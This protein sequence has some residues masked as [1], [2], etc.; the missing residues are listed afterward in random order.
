M[1]VIDSGIRKYG[2]FVGKNPFE[3]GFITQIVFLYFA[4]GWLQQETESGVWTELSLQRQWSAQGGLQEHQIRAWED[5][6]DD[7][8]TWDRYLII[9][10]QKWP[11][12]RD[13]PMDLATVQHFQDMMEFA[14][15]WF[16]ITVEVNGNTYSTHDLCRKG[17]YPA[18]LPS[19]QTMPCLTLSGFMCFAEWSRSLPA[20][21]YEIDKGTPAAAEAMLAGLYYPQST[22]PQMS[23]LTDAELKAVMSVR[24][25]YTLQRGCHTF[26]KTLVG[27]QTFFGGSD[28][29]VDADGIITNLPMHF[30]AMYYDAAPR[31]AWRLG[32]SEDELDTALRKH[33]N[34]FTA[35]MEDWHKT[36]PVLD[37][38]GAPS[39]SRIDEELEDQGEE[40]KWHLL[41][42]GAVITG[43]YAVSM[44]TS[45]TWPSYSRVTV[46]MQGNGTILMCLVAAGGFLLLI[47]FRMNL[48][49]ASA[50]PFITLGVG[51]DDMFVL[52]RTF[53]QLGADFVNT[54][55]VSDTVAEVAHKAG[56]GV[57]L[58]SACN[59]IAFGFSSWIPVAN[60]S[61]FCISASVCCIFNFIGMFTIHL[62]TLAY[63]AARVKYYLP[64]AWCAPCHTGIGCMCC[65]PSM[66]C[67]PNR[68]K[69]PP[70]Y[71]FDMWFND[72]IEKK[73]AP[74]ISKLAVS[75]GVVV[76]T[77]ALSVA[78]AISIETRNIGYTP[79]II[80]KD[81]SPLAKFLQVFYSSVKYYSAEVVMYD[82]D[83]ANNQG[84]LLDLF[85]RFNSDDLP[86]ASVNSPFLTYMYTYA[87]NRNLLFPVL[88]FSTFV[89]KMVTMQQYMAA[90][91]TLPAE[92]YTL[93]PQI[94]NHTVF[95][96]SG[97][98]NASVFYDIYREFAY[99]PMEAKTKE[100]MLQY[101]LAP[102]GTWI[103]SLKNSEWMCCNSG[104]F[105][106]YSDYVGNVN[107]FSHYNLTDGSNCTLGKGKCG[108][109]LAYFSFTIADLN[110]HSDYMFAIKKS[111]EL[112]EEAGFSLRH[113]FPMG[114]S[115]VYW[116]LFDMLYEELGKVFITS[117]CV[118]LIVSILLLGDLGAAL[119]IFVICMAIVLQVGGFIC[120]FGYGVDWNMFT[121]SVV[122]ASVAL[123]VE[124]V[125]HTVCFFLAA[126]GSKEEKIADAMKDA[127]IAIIEGSISTV[128]S[129]LPM[130]FHEVPFF[131][132]YYVLPMT[133]LVFTGV[134]NGCVFVPA[135]LILI[136]QTK[137][138]CC[139]RFAPTKEMIV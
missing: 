90:A 60:L 111:D 125:A 98:L 28:V 102:V 74:C 105:F 67:S 10:H 50:L 5:W 85:S 7:S 64:D 51:M 93:H 48:V 16:G 44:L 11:E 57:L 106:W 131:K 104:S 13:E 61:D 17:A 49:M 79:D 95:A 77:L 70:Y 56:K 53:T 15:T 68:G 130:A 23:N 52:T 109:R 46:G 22:R 39:V 71:G 97:I 86:G 139:S 120:F 43:I 35:S 128:I 88:Q 58:T 8:W 133:I 18:Y 45:F 115:Y 89:V 121:S 101:V 94:Y 37:A 34:A 65:P 42:A 9:F 1:G 112:I 135:I 66:P 78:G 126:Q 91:G 107:E 12:K 96:P 103:P 73:Y 29:E 62:A 82:V 54:H 84:A 92:A 122:M 59:T 136:D 99:F 119:V 81:G 138:C 116:K 69:P 113:V 47:G 40:V 114:T 123:A 100:D 36:Q 129:I 19:D 63:E 24:S 55:P 33:Q 25:P 76:F 6:R 127:F 83:I 21:L 108:V 75:V 38:A 134:G 118:N 80:A 30:A 41:I 124:D 117:A 4:G 72:A 87:G 20:P 2:Q 27:V 26:F 14:L 3:F 31:A 32:R 137:T 110:E 132:I